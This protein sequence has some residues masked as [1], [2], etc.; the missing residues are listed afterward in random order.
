MGGR[1]SI[2]TEASYAPQ[3]ST[4]AIADTWVDYRRVLGPEG[5]QR[6]SEANLNHRQQTKDELEANRHAASQLCLNH[7]RIF[8]SCQSCSHKEARTLKP[9]PRQTAQQPNLKTTA[10]SVSL[11]LKPSYLVNID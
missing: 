4:S 6:I 1:V 11:T 2:R 5:L 3:A 8:Q 10:R 7:T 9:S